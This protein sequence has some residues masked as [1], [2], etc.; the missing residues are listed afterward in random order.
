M[1]T[2]ILIV[3]DEE[4]ML[5]LLERSIRKEMACEIETAG[6]GQE[7]LDRI[8]TRVF[9]LVLLDMRM[10]G[11]DGMAVLEK[12]KAVD[13]WLTVVMMT[14]YGAIE[15]AVEAIKKGA[16]DFITKPFDL[17]EIL[18][19]IRKALEHGSLVRENMKLRERIDKEEA[20]QKFVGSSPAMQK[21]Y[22]TIRMIS[23]TDVTVLITGESGT[24]KNL[25]AK[26]IHALSP[27]KNMPFV[28]VSCPTVP[29][30]ILESEL[31][32]YAKGA[33]THAAQ[34][35]KGL[36][37][38]ADGGTIFLDEI[39]DISP[40]IQTKLLQVLEEKAFK[41][42]GQTKT[43]RSD[44]RVITATN[45]NLKK[46]MQEKQFRE[47]LY[48]RL[49]VVDVDLPPLRDRK[50]DIPVLAEF[51]LKKYCTRFKRD[52]KQ[53]STEVMELFFRND[54][55]GNVRELENVIKKGVVMAPGQTVTAAD[56][57]WQPSLADHGRRTTDFSTLPYRQAKQQVLEQFNLE[58]ISGLLQQSEGNVTR[59][60]RRCGLE[61]QSFQHIMKKYGIKS[62]TFRK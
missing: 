6:R 11:L 56:V 27:R 24:G 9:D 40:S 55:A 61:R 46:R 22:N 8:T 31:F 10:P 32:G 45:R 5:K 13:P 39:G 18:R 43:I 17:E 28:R 1:N 36:F 47:D 26:A 35:R 34:N 21:I 7:A 53:I 20:L 44:V 62:E 41:P 42:L 38:E 14:A 48:Y 4:D 52:L 33:F 58:Y 37:E 49:C 59:A 3:D 19:L 16:Y 50:E 60:A 51:F 23:Q 25:A 29:E 57:G 2:R 54:W 12:I 30:N 15:V